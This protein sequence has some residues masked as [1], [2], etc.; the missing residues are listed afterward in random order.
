MAVDLLTEVLPQIVYIDFCAF[1][2]KGVL[3]E[4]WLPDQQTAYSKVQSCI[5]NYCRQ[6]GSCAV[7]LLYIGCNNTWKL[8]A[9]Q[10]RIYSSIIFVAY[11]STLFRAALCT[12]S[13]GS[14]LYQLFYSKRR[15][16]EILTQSITME[17][18]GP[19][20]KIIYTLQI[21]DTF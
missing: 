14:I 20:T 21:W 2:V 18:E 8:L 5:H 13:G 15:C 12:L 19:V 1:A 6:V 10:K 4:F 16:F 9:L 3:T 11:N 7:S 17:N